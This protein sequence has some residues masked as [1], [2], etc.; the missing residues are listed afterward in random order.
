MGDEVL[1]HSNEVVE[2]VLLLQELA[3]LVPLP[4]HVTAAADVRDGIREA[5][6]DQAQLVAVE[7]G[8]IGHLI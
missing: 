1:S 5:A 6:V 7:P 2:G 8:V 3:V 4:A